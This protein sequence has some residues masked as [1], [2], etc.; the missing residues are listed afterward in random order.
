MKSYIF[1]LDRIAII[2][3]EVRVEESIREGFLKERNFLSTENCGDGVVSIVWVGSG[4]GFYC[5][6]TI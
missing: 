4:C 2:I 3:P 1:T 6:V 5:L